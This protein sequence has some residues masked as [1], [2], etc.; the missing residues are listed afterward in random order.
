MINDR[1]QLRS[2]GAEGLQRRGVAGFTLIELM[3][4]VAVVAVLAAIAYPSYQDA[5]RKSRRGQAK[6]DLVEYVAQAERFRTVNNT[7]V[8]FLFPGGVPTIQSPREAGSP[9]RYDLAITTQTVTDLVISA[10][11]VADQANDRCGDLS[12]ANTNEKTNSA[13]DLADCW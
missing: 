6:A 9:A 4:V 10:T 8:G 12:L 5:L 1:L 13:G 3:I 7:Y 11:A 2:A